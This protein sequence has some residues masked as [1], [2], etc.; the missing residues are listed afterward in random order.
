LE[1]KNHTNYQQLTPLVHYK[2]TSY[3][4]LTLEK[5]VRLYSRNPDVTKILTYEQLPQR[6]LDHYK[7]FLKKSMSMPAKT[8]SFPEYFHHRNTNFGGTFNAGKLKLR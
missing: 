1:F 2:N 6:G 5:N 3:N 4:I 7:T 8:Y